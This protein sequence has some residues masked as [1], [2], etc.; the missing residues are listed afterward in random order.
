MGTAQLIFVG[1]LCGGATGSHV[2]AS[3]VTGS[4]VSHVTGSLV[5]GALSG[6]MFCACGTG[7]CTISIVV[8]AFYR[9]DVSHVNSGSM[10]CACPA[11][12]WAIF[13]V[14]TKCSTVVQ[15]L[16]LPKV[17]KGHL[18]PS[19]RLWCVHAQ[20]DVVQYSPQ[21]GPFDRK[22]LVLFLLFFILII[23]SFPFSFK[24]KK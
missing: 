10:L 2:T 20:P 18:T 21:W 7:S 12:S 17:N 19:G 23:F 4:D 14:V 5:T 1:V 8:G 9:S 13:L 3:H 15:V 22:R 24:K 6:S 11:F 16:G